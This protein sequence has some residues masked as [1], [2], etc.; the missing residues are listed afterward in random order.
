MSRPGYNLAA[1]HCVDLL[2][3]AGLLRWGIVHKDG[4]VESMAT[5]LGKEIGE[6]VGQLIR[7]GEND[8]VRRIM[9]EI[10]CGEDISGNSLES[11]AEASGGKRA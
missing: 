9:V 10:L 5:A 6:S 3:L 7:A 4:T 1:S 2:V 8:L 11:K